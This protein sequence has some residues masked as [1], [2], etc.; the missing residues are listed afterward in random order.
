MLDTIEIT[1]ELLNA[2]RG[3]DG[4]YTRAQ[5]EVLGVEW[6]PPRGWRSSVV[7]RR[8]PVEVAEEFLELRDGGQQSLFGR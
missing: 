8:V 2:G 6:P 5:L 7:G 4:T 1:R 3:A